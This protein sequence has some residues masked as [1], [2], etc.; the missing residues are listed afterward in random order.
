[1][2]NHEKKNLKMFVK[3]NTMPKSISEEQD[4]R[5]SSLIPILSNTEDVEY[6]CF[7]V[8]V[9]KCIFPWGKYHQ[10]ET[11]CFLSVYI[12]HGALKNNQ[13]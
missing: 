4:L 12:P 10:G 3:P 2:K 1:M 8:K 13:K 11:F 9:P 5:K 6:Q 7:T